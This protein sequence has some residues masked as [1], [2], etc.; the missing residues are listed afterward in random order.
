MAFKMYGKSPM[1]KKLVGKQKNLPAQ[2]KAK[3]E[4]AP[5][6]PAKMAKDPAMKMK[7]APLRNDKTRRPS[8]RLGE[9]G[10]IP[11]KLQNLFRS[12][13]NKIKRPDINTET[14]EP[15][16]PKPKPK[17][18]AKT[19][20]KIE[21]KKVGKINTTKKS[22]G[23]KKVAVQTKA[24]KERAKVEKTNKTMKGKTQLKDTKLGKVKIGKGKNAKNLSDTKLGKAFSKGRAKGVA[25]R[26]ARAE[27]M[28]AA[29]AER[30]AKRKAKKN[31]K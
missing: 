18:K 8:Y 20:N 11:D 19:I 13:D 9:Q 16:K 31:K 30:I 25:E 22:E 24:E 4:A 12:K 27:R 21:P 17:P 1:T 28:A 14:S 10:L 7:K 6:S 23:P 29:K 26:K 5:E 15:V 2:L 3:I